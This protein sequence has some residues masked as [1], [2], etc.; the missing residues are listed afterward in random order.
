[1]VNRLFSWIFSST[2]RITPSL[3][4]DGRPLRGSSCIISR[5]LL[6]CL[7]HLRTIESLMACSPNT[8]Q[9]WRMSAG[10][11]FLAFKKR[12]TDRILHVAL[13]SIF[14]NVLKHTG[15]CV[16]V[17]RLSANS[18]VPSKRT[19]KLCTHEHHSDR[20]VAAAIF[21]NGTYFVV[22]PRSID[23]QCLGANICISFAWN[24]T[25]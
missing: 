17:V 20:S 1:M 7:T 5:H 8:S 14:L 15:R 21:A 6:K 19:N 18:S 12:I 10:L 2:A 13:F 25:E 23:C 24:R 3:T 9:S 16:N 11:M 4:T 22:I